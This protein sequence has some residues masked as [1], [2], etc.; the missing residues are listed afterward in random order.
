MN[1]SLFRVVKLAAALALVGPWPWAAASAGPAEKPGPNASAAA[2]HAFVQVEIPQSVFPVPGHP[3]D[4]RNPFFPQSTLGLPQPKPK[5][6]LLDTS[7][8]VLNGITPSGPKRTAIIN[9]RTFEIGEEGEVK[10]PSGAKAMIKCEDIKTDTAVILY[11]GQ[12]R[13]LRLRLGVF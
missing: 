10:L 9:N 8:F 2:S 3:R 5:E 7:S 6:V 4:G 11:A 1:S 13:E 12:R